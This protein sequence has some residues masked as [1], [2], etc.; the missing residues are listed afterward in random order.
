MLQ[1]IHSY[2]LKVD[3]S[4]IRSNWMPLVISAEV[5]LTFMICVIIEITRKCI[6]KIPEKMLISKLV[7]IE[8][9]IEKLLRRINYGKVMEYL[10]K[11]N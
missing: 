11:E 5:L 10:K 1:I 3:L 2:I 6:L 4:I 8:G 9:S 7:N